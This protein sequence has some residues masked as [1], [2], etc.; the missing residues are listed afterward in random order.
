VGNAERPISTI[1]EIETSPSVRVCMSLSS[2]D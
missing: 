2:R 1:L